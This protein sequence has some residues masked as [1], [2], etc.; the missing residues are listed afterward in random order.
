[1]PVRKTKDGFTAAYGGK[2]KK[3]KTYNAAE[4]WASKYRRPKRT[5]RTSRAY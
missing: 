2:T 5:G 4:K 1:M 3:F